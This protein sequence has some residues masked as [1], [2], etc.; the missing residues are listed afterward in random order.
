MR[1][2]ASLR[3]SRTQAAGHDAGHLAGALQRVCSSKLAYFAVG[4]GIRHDRLPQLLR[5]PLCYGSSP[6][7]GGLARGFLN[8]N[9]APGVPR[10]L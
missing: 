9:S 2:S 4:S 3:G 10:H 1:L 5:Q 6:G 7:P 8:E